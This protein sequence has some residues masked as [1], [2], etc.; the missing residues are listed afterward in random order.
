MQRGA[1]I[2]QLNGK[3]FNGHQNVRGAAQG[4]AELPL[5]VWGA[6]LIRAETQTVAMPALPLARS[7]AEPAGTTGLRNA[8]VL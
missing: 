5:Q 1:E 4:G 3:D 8:A 2:E 6:A 7:A